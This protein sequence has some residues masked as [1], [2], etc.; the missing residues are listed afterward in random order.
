MS[1][2]VS[3]FSEP[4][5]SANTHSGT[6]LPQQYDEVIGLDIPQVRALRTALACK[7]KAPIVIIGSFGT[8]KTWLLAHL[9]FQIL[10]KE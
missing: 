5:A 4:S 1:Q 2:E 10:G 8:G 3:D 6:G 9:A 7:P